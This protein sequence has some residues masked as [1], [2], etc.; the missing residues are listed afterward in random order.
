VHRIYDTLPQILESG[1]TVLLVEQD[2]SQAQ[3]VATRLQCL[4][5]GRTTLEGNPEDFTAEQIEAAYF[6]VSDPPGGR[7]PVPPGREPDPETLSGSQERGD[8]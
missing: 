5:E 1:I 6:G 4:L 7:P 8:S 3:R 2:V